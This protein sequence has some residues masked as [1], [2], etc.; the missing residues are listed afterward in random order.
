M[1]QDKD[2]IGILNARSLGYYK[3]DNRALQQNPINYQLE[4]LNLL[5]EQSSEYSDNIKTLSEVQTKQPILD[6]TSKA[7]DIYLW[8]ETND[9]CS[10][11]NK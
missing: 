1:N 4:N 7:T 2:A 3:I 9:P 8:S 6:N 11:L 5:C 10:H